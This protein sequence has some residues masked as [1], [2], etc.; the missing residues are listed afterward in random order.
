MAE[1]GINA[2]EAAS[3]VDLN[4]HL[5]GFKRDPKTGELYIEGR[6][7]KAM[8]KESANIRWPYPNVVWGPNG[9]RKAA[10]VKGEGRGKV[11]SAFFAE[12][13]FVQEDQIGLGVTEPT[14]VVQ[15]FVQTWRGSAIQ[16]EE[17]IDGP[18]VSFTVATDYDFTDEQW[19]L[20]WLTA[21]Q[22]GLGATRSQGYGR[23]E[24]VE[25]TPIVLK[26]GK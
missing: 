11:S 6:Q 12:H 3:V 20:L 21:E 8:L 10:S 2:E 23:F 24:V 19:A 16:Y 1:R 14:G 18:V 9:P 4:K 25:W 22:N 26:K 5:N 15:R 7:V 17:Y 13:V